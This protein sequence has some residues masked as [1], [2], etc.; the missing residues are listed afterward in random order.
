MNRTWRNVIATSALCVMV[1]L[2]GCAIFWIGAGVAGGVAVGRDKATLHIDQPF[3]DTWRVTKSV[4]E[5]MGS[6]TEYD[7]KNGTVKGEIG[8]AKIK[9]RV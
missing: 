8:D 5:D 6:V 2:S 9:T 3:Q 4:V 1:P 7:D